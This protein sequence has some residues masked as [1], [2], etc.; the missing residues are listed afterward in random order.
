MVEQFKI[1]NQIFDKEFL[2]ELNFKKYFNKNKNSFKTKHNRLL[3]YHKVRA[4]LNL[5]RLIRNRAFHF[6]NMLK[7]N[8]KGP[9]LSVKI[10]NKNESMIISIHPHKICDFLN[11]LLESFHKDL[12]NYAESGGKCR[13]ESE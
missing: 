9:R 8:E 7:M 6:E 4:I 12:I 2:D 1:H 13:L 11:D 10:S 5:L 3:R